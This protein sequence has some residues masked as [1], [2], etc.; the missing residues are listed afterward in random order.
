MTQL[1][2]PIACNRVREL[3]DGER[4]AHIDLRH[5][6]LD[7]LGSYEPPTYRAI[8]RMMR[9]TGYTPI[10]EWGRSV[11]RLVAKLHEPTRPDDRAR[12][13]RSLHLSPGK[14]VLDI[15]CGPGAFSAL[16]GAAVGNDG[17]AIGID[18]SAQM[19]QRA[20][21]ENGGT[22]VAYLRADAERL[23]LTDEAADAVTCLAAL[24]LINGPFQA[25]DE[26]TRVLRSGGRIVILTSRAPGGSTV[27]R[28]SR[29]LQAFS[30][31][32]MFGHDEI[33][34]NLRE[35]GFIDIEQQTGGWSQTITATKG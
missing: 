13:I 5:G 6:Y 32:R 3:L 25:L 35:R 21:S 2:A 27:T 24:Y 28:A 19:L 34:V 7:V 22:S 11:F 4:C 26:M 9:S 16:F 29:A 18:A 31:I 30:G 17:L 23:P 10:Y 12:I 1:P 8:Q 15:G 20:V 33:V 14:T